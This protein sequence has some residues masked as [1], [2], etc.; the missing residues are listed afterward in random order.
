MSRIDA[1]LAFN[2]A[3]FNAAFARSHEFGSAMLRFDGSNNT[4][5]FRVTYQHRLYYNL[6][7]E[8]GQA[9]YPSP[10]NRAWKDRV[11][12]MASKVAHD[13]PST[14]ARPSILVSISDATITENDGV[15]DE[16]PRPNKSKVGE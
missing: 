15:N 8:T 12:E 5:T 4:G 3:K 14:R 7:Q 11:L 10:L 1:G 6:T 9:A 16:Q 13:F 2:A